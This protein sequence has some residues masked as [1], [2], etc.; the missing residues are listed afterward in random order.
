[1]TEKDRKQDA[2]PEGG[3]T[4]DERAVL[5]V[6]LQG[7]GWHMDDLRREAGIANVDL[8][9][10]TKL[11]RAQMISN[12][13]GRG[14]YV[15]D[16]GRAAIAQTAPV[17]GGSDGYLD[18]FNAAEAGNGIDLTLARD[19]GYAK[20]WQRG[21]IGY[22]TITKTER[23]QAEI[24]ALES[25]LAAAGAAL[26]VARGYIEK[27]VNADKAIGEHRMDYGHSDGLSLRDAQQRDG[28]EIALERLIDDAGTTLA[29][30]AALKQP[31]AGEGK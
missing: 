1:M 26:E 21:Y 17:D 19:L 20:A 27:I 29:K 16:A 11:V 23:Q 12:Q 9:C 22:Q 28:L 2:Q 13:M 24:R 30:L 10:F 4:D 3:L 7:H 18:G 5:E 14:Y 8:A 6:M 25:K 15:T 31:S